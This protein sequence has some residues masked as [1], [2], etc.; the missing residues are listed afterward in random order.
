[1]KKLFFLFVCVFAVQTTQ[2]Q[3]SKIVNGIS[4]ARDSIIRNKKL[5]DGIIKIFNLDAYGA[6]LAVATEMISF[7][8]LKEMT[9]S[10]LSDEEVLAVTQFY[11]TVLWYGNLSLERGLNKE[12]DLKSKES[13]WK[14]IYKTAS[15]QE[16]SHLSKLCSVTLNEVKAFAAEK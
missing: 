16:Q 8:T 15:D 13:S 4:N 1:M 11:V 9:K 5:Q 10:P 2:A 6:C 3:D 14:E 12:A 7:A